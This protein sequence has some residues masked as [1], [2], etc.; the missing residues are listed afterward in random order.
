[1]KGA[2]EAEEGPPRSTNDDPA[3]RERVDVEVVELSDP[4]AARNLPWTRVYRRKRLG[5]ASSYYDFHES[6]NRRQQADMVVE[7]VN[8]EAPIHIDYAIRRVAEAW[9]ISRLGHRVVAA[10]R[11]AIQQA[12]RR[13]AVEVRGDFLWKPGQALTHVRVPDPGDPATRREINEIAP[14]EIDLA[15]ARLSEASA[16]LDADQIVS[17]VA[18]VLGFE[19]TGGRIQNAIGTRL[20]QVRPDALS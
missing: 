11:Q 9:G 16:G 12:V 19:R 7:L 1:M 13:K 4:D 18:R 20:R 10:G 17:Q 8:L 15:L 3:P 2:L 14:E 6:V 5:R